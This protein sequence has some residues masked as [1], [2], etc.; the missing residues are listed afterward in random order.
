[1]DK[2]KKVKA[3]CI[4]GVI[5]CLYVVLFFAARAVKGR[6]GEGS[7]SALFSQGDRFS[8]GV[9][10]TV[11]Y[12]AVTAGLI[13]ASLG[14]FSSARARA[15]KWD[16]ENEDEIE[17][18]EDMLNMPL[19]F[20]N[21]MQTTGIGF[22]TCCM[23]LLLSKKSLTAAVPAVIFEV[24]YL[25]VLIING[26]VVELEK[27]LNPEKKGSM[28]DMDFGRKWLDSCDEGEKLAIYRAAYGALNATNK[29]FFIISV[30]LWA[31]QMIF[32][33]GLMPVISVTVLWS[34]MNIS[35][36]RASMKKEK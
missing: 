26:R 29:A 21:I 15:E 10:L 8:A 23:S 18:I 34:I 35:F 25:F 2:K 32:D 24:S 11:V 5:L 36:I 33:T 6:L 1:M 13:T 9:V 3:A 28:T 19:M 20:T 17:K 16:G 4:A 30:V 12:A 31:L 22:L 7:F 27:K 14:V